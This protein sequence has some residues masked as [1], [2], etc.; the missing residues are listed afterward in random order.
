LE[1]YP[2]PQTLVAQGFQAF[3]IPGFNDGPPCPKAGALP[4]ALIPVIYFSGC[5]VGAPKV[6]PT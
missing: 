2:N 4:T 3:Y 1:D 6:N 5:F